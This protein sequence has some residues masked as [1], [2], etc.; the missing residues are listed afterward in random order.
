MYYV[1]PRNLTPKYYLMLKKRQEQLQEYSKAPLS[2]LYICTYL[3]LACPYLASQPS[4]VV[5]RNECHTDIIKKKQQQKHK[6]FHGGWECLCHSLQA[7]RP[8][9]E[10]YKINYFVLIE[11]SFLWI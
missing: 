9:K 7:C 11:V 5:L 1:F 10:Q 2:Y 3:Y 6:S 8:E 4:C